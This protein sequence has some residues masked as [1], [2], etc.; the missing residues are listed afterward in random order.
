MSAFVLV[1]YDVTDERSFQRYRELAGPTHVPYGGTLV[2]K[3]TRTIHLEGG[4][5][6]LNDLVILGFPTAAD[7]KAWYNSEE[8]QTAKAARSGAA[9]MEI[10]I[11]EG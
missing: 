7:A 2:A 8:Y 10:S 5:D 6:E 4:G 11:I 9:Q 3:G 1:R